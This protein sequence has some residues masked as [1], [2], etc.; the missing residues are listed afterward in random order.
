MEIGQC[1]V[2]ET[3]FLEPHTLDREMERSKEPKCLVRL[4]VLHG[5]IREGFTEGA[6]LELGLGG[7]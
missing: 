6:I 1:S 4:Q 7:Q 2:S 5:D 3:S